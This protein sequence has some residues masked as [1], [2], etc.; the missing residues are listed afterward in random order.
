MPSHR[1]ESVHDGHHD[2]ASVVP[3]EIEEVDGADSPKVDARQPW[4]DRELKTLRKVGPICVERL[5]GYLQRQY[6]ENST[7]AYSPVSLIKQPQT[8]LTVS[9]PFHWPA[10]IKTLTHMQHHTST[11]H[12]N[13]HPTRCFP[14]NEICEHSEN[15][16]TSLRSE[17]RE[18]FGFSHLRNLSDALSER[19]L[20]T[21][22]ARIISFTSN[23]VEAS[24]AV[25][26]HS[27]NCEIHC[28]SFF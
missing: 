8:V 15:I 5:I 4:Q 16:W 3:L 9:E 14:W 18:R 27:C 2:V 23:L 13:T 17:G 6:M 24:S 22:S 10:Q 19:T 1:F 7:L 25:W 28:E 20:I 21:L 26:R 12:K 11:T